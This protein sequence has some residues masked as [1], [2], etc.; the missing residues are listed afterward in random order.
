MEPAQQGAVS[1]HK[2]P[3]H[4]STATFVSFCSLHPVSSLTLGVCACTASSPMLEL[5]WSLSPLL[6]SSYT[7]VFSEHPPCPLPTLWFVFSVL[8]QSEMSLSLDF[9]F[10]LNLVFIAAS[11]AWASLTMMVMSFADGMIVYDRRM[12]VS[13]C[14]EF[15][16]RIKVW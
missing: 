12:L 13:A 1:C 9:L 6:C 8:P 15:R 14:S 3:S 11:S 7:Q 4:N 5:L 16:K 2:P 10:S